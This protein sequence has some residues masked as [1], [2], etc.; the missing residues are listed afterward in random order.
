MRIWK[1]TEHLLIITIASIVLF[2]PI[3]SRANTAIPLGD[4]VYITTDKYQYART[5]NA[6]KTDFG[7]VCSQACT[8]VISPA[9]IC[10]SK[11]DINVWMIG[12]GGVKIKIESTCMQHEGQSALVLKNYDEILKAVNRN[13]QLDFLLNLDAKGNSQ[14]SFNLLGWGDV[15]RFIKTSK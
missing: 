12:Q 7:I 13:S 8:F 6:N 11:K 2:H 5:R 10:E 15:K 4:W 9:V 14:M 3:A 1:L